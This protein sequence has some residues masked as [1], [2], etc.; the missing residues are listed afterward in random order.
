MRILVTG[1]A[2][3]VGSHTCV[4]LMEAG[5]EVAILDNFHNAARDVPQ[6]LER[7]GGRAVVVFEGDVRDGALLQRV[8]TPGRFDALMHFAALKSVAESVAEPLSY[9]D[10]NVSGSVRLFEAALQAGVN[11]I[12]FSSSALVYSAGAT[13]PLAETAEVAP[14]NPYGQ[15][16]LAVER[17]LSALCAGRPYLRP[18]SLRYFNPVGAHPSGLIG[19]APNGVPANLFPVA[20]QVAAGQRPQLDIFGNDYDTRDGTAVRD[21]LHVMDVAEG[22]VAALAFLAGKDELPDSSAVNLGSGTGSTVLEMKAAFDAALGRTLPARLAPRR[23][24]DVPVLIADTTL[25]RR[26]FNWSARRSIADACRDAIR[27]ARLA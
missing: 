3:Y 11:N 25:A 27:W 8:L 19:E 12:L 24:G 22:H 14:A 1:G 9:W 18:L 17:M 21:Y 6:R 20:M 2:G 4:A 13:P 15:T 26:L 5:H 16:K 7:L 23:A 10:V